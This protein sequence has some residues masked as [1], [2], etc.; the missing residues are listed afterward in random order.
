MNM[1]LHRLK[2]DLEV[3]GPFLSH[4]E[5]SFCFGLDMASRHYHGHPVLNG[6]HLR[7][8]L[9]HALEYFS[10]KLD[11]INKDIPANQLPQ[12][13][14]WFGRPSQEDYEARHGRLTFDPF[15]LAKKESSRIKRYRIGINDT[16]GTVATGNLQAMQAI[17]ESGEK[18]TFSGGILF[19]GGDD[20]FETLKK[21]L[22]KALQ[23]ISSLGALKS[24]GY[25]KLLGHTI[26][27]PE[28]KNQD[29]RS[30]L[31]FFDGKP[32]TLELDFRLD[33]PFCVAQPHQPDSNRFVSEDII[34]GSVF[35]GALAR[36]WSL[37]QN[38]ELT[39][40]AIYR[41]LTVRHTQA[42]TLRTGRSLPQPLSLVEANGQL[43][44]A[45][46]HDGCFLLRDANG[47]SHAPAFPLDWKERTRAMADERLQKIKYPLQLKPPRLLT[48]RTAIENESAAADPGRLFSLEC[49]D[50]GWEGDSTL[51][52]TRWSIDEHE[53][54]D[55]DLLNRLLEE[56]QKHG[57]TNIGKT[58]AHARLL[59]IRKIEDTPKLE[60]PNDGL[61]IVLLVSPA[62]MLSASHQL[63]ASGGDLHSVYQ[64]YF[65]R[66]SEDS[67][68]LRQF[69][70]RQKLY[71]GTFYWKKY[72]NS[73]P[74]Y[75]PE[76]MTEA[77]SVFVL[78]AA[79]GKEQEAL[80][81][82]QCCL[83]FGLPDAKDSR[84]DNTFDNPLCASNGFGEITINHPIHRAMAYPDT[85]EGQLI[86]CVSGARQP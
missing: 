46:Q 52:R 38:K 55:A 60:K 7:G 83:D 64:A 75:R 73:K 51:W 85:D 57:L 27:T 58:K 28:I 86:P 59:N 79:S 3:Q 69:F 65:S 84:E 20:E 62:R 61:F 33:R 70:A 66:V 41:R 36:Q 72:C 30:D 67:I 9:R 2:I 5:G 80:S 56:L 42:E 23:Y 13:D 45:T 77:G 78:E 34:P 71:G 6:S 35:K 49:I 37:A 25:G 11:T 74:D 14:N 43:L 68:K 8:H 10:K 63:P 26:N 16:T 4:T 47:N 81:F 53:K 12:I 40:S 50:T 48:V 15:W 31:S 39:G 24:V 19:W 22:D 17:G 21:W 18:L 1:N 82:L 76:W 32:T 54:E 44:D 29:N